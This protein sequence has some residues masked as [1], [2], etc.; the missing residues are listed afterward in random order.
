ML[1]KEFIGIVERNIEYKCVIFQSFVKFDQNPNILDKNNNK[2]SAVIIIH[3]F[4]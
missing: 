1:L 3:C 2:L 4:S